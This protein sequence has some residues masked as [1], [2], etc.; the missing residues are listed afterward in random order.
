VQ[1]VSLSTHAAMVVAV[2]STGTVENHLIDVPGDVSDAR[3]AAASSRLAQHLVGESSGDVP[4]V[5]PSGDDTVDRLC[6]DAVAV[7]RRLGSQEDDHVFV[8]GAAR[9]AA[10]FDA[11]EI[12]RNVLATLEQQYVVVTLLRD[13]LDRGLS[14]AIG[15]EHGV[16]PLVACSVVVAPYRVEGERAGTIG[17]LGPTRMNYPEALAAVE[18]VSERLGRRLSDG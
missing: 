11:V 18:L 16:E 2:L 8:G 1:L 13:V 14:V 6:T 7:L 12:V 9:M 17:V 5:T 4:D 15:A 10:A 3:I